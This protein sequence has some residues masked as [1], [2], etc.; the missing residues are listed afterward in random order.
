MSQ[1]PISCSYCTP[2]S[3]KNYSPPPTTYSSGH[4]KETHLKIEDTVWWNRGHNFLFYP[5]LNVG[6]PIQGCLFHVST[7]VHQQWGGSSRQAMGVNKQD[8]CGSLAPESPA[9]HHVCTVAH[10]NAFLASLYLSTPSASVNDLVSLSK[11]VGECSYNHTG[12]YNHANH[13]N[14]DDIVLINGAWRMAYLFFGTVHTHTS[15]FTLL[16]WVEQHE[17]PNPPSA[18]LLPNVKVASYTFKM[19][20]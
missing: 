14:I 17:L 13:L 7:T 5:V 6:S 10:L 16:Y 2:S 19:L 11:R 3:K 4:M 9:E 15:H 18:A 20:M 8:G 12:K 1:P